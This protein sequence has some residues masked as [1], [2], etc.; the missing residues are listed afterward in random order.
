[1]SANPLAPSKPQAPVGLYALA[2][3][4]A[5]QVRQDRGE[6]WSAARDAARRWAKDCYGI[7]V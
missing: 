1:M 2:T 4:R 7:E 6:S 5:A 3:L